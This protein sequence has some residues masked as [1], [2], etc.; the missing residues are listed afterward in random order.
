[1]VLD[2]ELGMGPWQ[3]V[4]YM[5]CHV[6]QALPMVAI[7]LHACYVMY[8]NYCPVLGWPLTA[9]YAVAA[10][11]LLPPCLRGCNLPGQ[12]VSAYLSLCCMTPA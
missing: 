8:Y 2:V 10:A 5:L 4:A 9:K 3:A 6:L 1:M 11:Q 7:A 12:S